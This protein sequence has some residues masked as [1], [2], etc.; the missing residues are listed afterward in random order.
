[1]AQRALLFGVLGPRF[2]ESVG[3][4][5][6]MLRLFTGVV[7]W[8]VVSDLI[9]VDVLAGKTSSG[10]VSVFSRFWELVGFLMVETINFSVYFGFQQVSW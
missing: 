2:V 10:S 1:M 5:V 4:P 9:G 3:T 6:T 7:F 8:V